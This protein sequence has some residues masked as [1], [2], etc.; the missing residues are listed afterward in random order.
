[1]AQDGRSQVGDWEISSRGKKPPTGFPV[2]AAHPLSDPAS[3]SPKPAVNARRGQPTHA[4]R[5]YRPAQ[6]PA[7]FHT[8]KK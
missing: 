3:K 8:N 4:S 5:E 6:S 7:S 1:M 2:P